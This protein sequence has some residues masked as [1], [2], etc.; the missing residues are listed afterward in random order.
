MRR[1]DKC[2]IVGEDGGVMVETDNGAWCLSA[3]ASARIAAL[4]SRLEAMTKDR[5]A[6]AEAVRV[7]GEEARMWRSSLTYSAKEALRV[8]LEACKQTEANPIAAAAV[9]G[10]GE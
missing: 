8:S 9:K 7:L 1:Y 10:G 5:D 3:E 6:Q 2:R 4:E